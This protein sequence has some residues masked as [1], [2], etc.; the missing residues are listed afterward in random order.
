MGRRIIR[1]KTAAGIYIIFV[2]D[3]MIADVRE[4][5]PGGENAITGGK[6]LSC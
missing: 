6:N 1:N 3:A 2:D 4:K 5:H